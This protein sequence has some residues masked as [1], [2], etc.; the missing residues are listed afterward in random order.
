MTLT[1]P[2]KLLNRRFSVAPMLDWTDHHERYFLRLISKN[3][4]LYTEMI[5]TGALIH[6]ER[7][8]YLHYNTEEH[9]IALQLGGSNPKELSICTQ[10]AVDYGYDEINLNVG[11]PSQRV[12]KGA[13]GACLMREPS[14]V[15]DCV[16]TM[17]NKANGRPITVK[18]RIGVDD[19]EGYEKLYYFIQTVAEAG[20]QTFIIH[21]RKALLKG[22]SPKENRDIPPLDYPMVYQLKKDF[23]QLN[24]VINGGIK[25]LAACTQHLHHVDGVM[26]GREAYHNPYLLAHVDQQFYDSPQTSPSR[27]QILQQYLNYIQQQ[28]KKGIP[29]NH[30]TRHILGL[31]H[32][33]QGAKAWRRHLSEYGSRSG[34]NEKVVHKAAGHVNY[35]PLKERA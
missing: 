30:M 25:T 23:P 3:A 13:F 26:I 27:E 20:C 17:Q 9:P 29:L 28:L 1:S 7:D 5:T 31:Y 12:Q 4:L 14:L 35:P 6:G 10:M 8:R 2:L 19:H 24:L 15:A 18:N 32:G 22:L 16:N 34:A 11:C 33:I 21:A